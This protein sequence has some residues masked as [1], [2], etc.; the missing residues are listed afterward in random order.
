MISPLNHSVP[1]TNQ[2]SVKDPIYSSLCQHR[3][4]AE[5]ADPLIIAK[6][7]HLTMRVTSNTAIHSLLQSALS[8]SLT[9]KHL[10]YVNIYL[11]SSN[12][13]LS[14]GKRTLIP[15]KIWRKNQ[16]IQTMSV[17]NAIV[18]SVWYLTGYHFLIINRWSQDQSN[19]LGNLE[20]GMSEFDQSHAN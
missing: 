14:V 8:N 13:V 20:H 3:N 16:D 7:K 5:K 6:P 12:D 18:I 9:H 4:S 15:M 19:A 17:R 11:I 10:W 2:Y 1:C